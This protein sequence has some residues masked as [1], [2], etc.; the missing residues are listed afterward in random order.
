MARERKSLYVR[1]FDNNVRSRDLAILFETR[2]GPL[3]RIDFPHSKKGYNY[4]FVEFVHNE[5]AD[6][7]IRLMDGYK[8]GNDHL[9]IHEA[10]YKKDH[11]VVDGRNA[12][13]NHDNTYYRPYRSPIRSRLGPRRPPSR[14]PVELVRF[15]PRPEKV[16]EREERGRSRT[17]SVSKTS[18]HPRS[19]SP[20]S[21]QSVKHEVSRSRS[22]SSSTRSQ[23]VVE[24]ERSRSGSRSRSRSNSCSR[25]RSRSRSQCS[26]RSAS[27][28]RD[29]NGDEEMEDGEIEE[30]GEIVQE[31]VKVEDVNEEPVENNKWEQDGDV[32]MFDEDDIIDFD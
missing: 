20:R 25:S 22:R 12:H 15:S 18:S 4:G 9:R 10:K 7:A 3:R 13:R 17:R 32:L 21:A 2:V 29:V 5:D 6:K 1:G 27:V 19:L 26:S 11:T 14:S 16:D 8:F 30:E 24:S 28:E 23:S 31:D